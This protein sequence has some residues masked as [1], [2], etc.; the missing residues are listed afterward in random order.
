MRC[1]VA[2][3]LDA[4][5]RDTLA[6]VSGIICRES[7]AWCDEKW[8]SPSNLHVTLAFLG[9]VEEDALEQLRERLTVIVAETTPFELG[10]LSL[11]AVPSPSR[12]TMLWAHL[13]DPSG[14]CATLATSIATSCA[15]LGPESRREDRRPFKAHVTLCRARRPRRLD[16]RV[17]EVAN[18]AV[19]GH[20][21]MMSV[22]RVS[23]F[24]SRLTPRGPIYTVVGTWLMRGE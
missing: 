3:E 21:V 10:P 14:A 16:A 19:L 15:E 20:E 11:R 17:L 7:L 4:A 18:E 1:F 22:P 9:E 5:T 2:I 8:V 13:E 24:S 23:L 6:E 12:T